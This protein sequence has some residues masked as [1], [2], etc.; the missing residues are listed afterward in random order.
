MAYGVTMSAS[1]LRDLGP[2]RAFLRGAAHRVRLRLRGKSLSIPAYARNRVRSRSALRSGAHSASSSSEKR[3]RW[4]SER[5]EMSRPCSFCSAPD[6]T[7]PP[8]ALR[9]V[10]RYLR[11][12]LQYRAHTPAPASNAVLLSKLQ[13]AATEPTVQ[14]RGLIHAE[15][16]SDPRGPSIAPL[17]HGLSSSSD[18]PG[19]SAASKKGP[20]P[21]GCGGKPQPCG[22][23]AG[24][25]P[26]GHPPSIR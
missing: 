25:R 10:G 1:A 2:R 5:E 12:V 20:L 9:D 24:Q 4:G 18:S 15:R 11:R 17:S 23:N 22:W 3:S 13:I 21:S 7:R 16:H 8:A 14:N 6:A 26:S 19:R